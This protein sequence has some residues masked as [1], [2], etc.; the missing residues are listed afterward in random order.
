MDGDVVNSSPGDLLFFPHDELHSGCLTWFA[1]VRMF[2]PL[3]VQLYPHNPGIV[4]VQHPNL[5]TMLDNNLDIVKVFSVMHSLDIR[6]VEL[7]I[8][9]VLRCVAKAVSFYIC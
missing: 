4:P 7:G 9:A 2:D 3:S 1:L 5:S 8:T 6:L